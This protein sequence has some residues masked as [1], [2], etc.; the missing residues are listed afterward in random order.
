MPQVW[1][2]SWYGYLDHSP[3]AAAPF[4]SFPNSMPKLSL[5]LDLLHLCTHL[6][7]P[8]SRNPHLSLSHVLVV[9]P[10]LSVKLQSNI[11]SVMSSVSLTPYHDYVVVRQI[12]SFNF[13]QVCLDFG[14]RQ[15]VGPSLVVPK[16]SLLL[17]LWLIKFAH[18][19]Q[20]SA[21]LWAPSSNQSFWR[22]PLHL[23]KVNI[24]CESL[25]VP[26]PGWPFHSHNP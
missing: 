26:P 19:H 6:L 5:L 14:L 3:V 24:Y 12:P 25:V 11:N 20:P 1:T 21:T 18:V 2:E 8:K 9:R 13:N 17:A 7:R 4:R 10:T 23:P 16:T 15:C 22:T